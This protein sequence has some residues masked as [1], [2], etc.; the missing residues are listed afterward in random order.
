M[1]LDSKGMGADGMGTRLR[2]IP[3]TYFLNLINIKIIFNIN[4]GRLY[5]YIIISCKNTRLGKIFV[6]IC[7]SNSSIFVVKINYISGI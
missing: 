6:K 5:S 1:D 3:K 7:N 2:W 4:Y